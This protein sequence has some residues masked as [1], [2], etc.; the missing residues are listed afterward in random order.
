MNHESDPKINIQTLPTVT[1]R[2]NIDPL[3]LSIESQA[4][5][6]IPLLNPQSTTTPREG[7]CSSSTD[8]VDKGNPTG[9]PTRSST[10]L[11]I[12]PH[13][14]QM[15]HPHIVLITLTTFSL[16]FLFILIQMD[17]IR[18]IQV[19]HSKFFNWLLKL[20]RSCLSHHLCRVHGLTILLYPV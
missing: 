7:Y 19:D 16:G 18:T 6:H 15:C 3:V 5:K 9:F 2:L 10:T 14:P 13:P 17:M 4:C 11:Y 1:L 20:I 12:D 8:S